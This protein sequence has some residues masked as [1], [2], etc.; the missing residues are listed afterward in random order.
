MTLPLHALVVTPSICY[1]LLAPRVV[2][3]TSLHYILCLLM[4]NPYHVYWP[5]LEAPMVSCTVWTSRSYVHISKLLSGYGR[6]RLTAVPLTVCG[7]K[8]LWSNINNGEWMTESALAVKNVM[9]SDGTDRAYQ[10]H[11]ISGPDVALPDT[12]HWTCPAVYIELPVAFSQS[13][14]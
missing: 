9:D 5:F 12:D 3:R 8:Y 7:M 11:L 6:L 1:H 4:L 2:F 14:P 10:R 13:H